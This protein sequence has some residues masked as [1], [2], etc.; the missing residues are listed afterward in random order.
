MLSTVAEQELTGVLRIDAGGEIWVVGGRT[1]LATTLGGPDLA[2][3]LFDSGIGSAEA[4]AEALTPSSDPADRAAPASGPEAGGSEP[5][6]LDR[7]LAARPDA[8]PALERVLHEHSL[9]SLFEM[10]VPSQAEFRFDPGVVHPLGDRFT[11][12]TGELVAKAQQRLEIWRRIA[13]RIPSTSAVFSLARSLP[14]QLDQRLV[15][16]E[17]WRFLSLLDGRNTVADIINETGESAFRVCS[18]LY[19][20]LLENLVEEAGDTAEATEPAGAS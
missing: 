9:N 20:L 11:T 3:V 17:E 12:D 18:S 6:A 2:R 8:V 14:D 13:A 10:L 4:I 19:R 7:L 5:S 16:A 15:T 1:C